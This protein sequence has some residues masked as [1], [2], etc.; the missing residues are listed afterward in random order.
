MHQELWTID[1]ILQVKCVLAAKAREVLL[2][3]ES[4]REDIVAKRQPRARTESLTESEK[5][6]QDIFEW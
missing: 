5:R 1:G 2:L 4:E 6:K 3:W